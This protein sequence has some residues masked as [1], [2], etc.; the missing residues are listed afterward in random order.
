MKEKKSNQLKDRC[1]LALL[2]SA[3][4]ALPGMDSHGLEPPASDISFQQAHYQED[5]LAS[6]IDENGVSEKNGQ[7]M[8][9][10]VSQLSVRSKINNHVGVD[11]NLGHEVL[12]GASPWFVAKDDEGN[13]V[14]VLSGPSIEET[15]D[16]IDVQV[17][18]YSSNTNTNIGMTYSQE[19]DYTSLGANGSF[20]LEFNKKLTTLSAGIGISNDTIT[21]VDRERFP[22]RVESEDKKSFK[23]HVSLSHILSR[24]TVAQFTLGFTEHTGFLSD[25][26]KLAFVEGVP[27]P[28]NR[29]SIKSQQTYSFLLRHHMPSVNSTVH[30]NYRYYLDN[31][32]VA[33]HTLTIDWYKELPKQWFLDTTFRYY[34]QREAIFYDVYYDRTRSDQY[35]SSDYRL[36]NFGS[37]SGGISLGKQLGKWKFELSAERYQSDENLS[38][39][40]NKKENPGLT[41]FS[42]YSLGVSY[43]W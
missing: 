42:L 40:S 23:T 28:D 15:R 17:G 6:Y 2:T 38:F 41:N 43:N 30:M 39:D 19:N 27:I 37:I 34:S 20:N 36:S 14:Q 8:T 16:D 3:A 13:P 32:N 29:P 5:K 26:Y 7:R 24:T 25:P 21:P 11:I 35:Y 10:S 1:S 22:M 18:F 9:I 12:S 4:L 31:W 33:A